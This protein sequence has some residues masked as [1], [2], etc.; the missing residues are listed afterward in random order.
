M[1]VLQIIVAPELNSQ[2]EI[3]IN[4]PERRSANLI[5]NWKSYNINPVVCY[6]RWGQL[7]SVF[8]KAEVLLIDYDCGPKSNWHAVCD[9][10]TIVKR[11]K[12]DLIHTQGSP[13]VD[14]WAS[15]AGYYSK[16]PNIV[17]RPSM[18]AQNRR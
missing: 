8:Q 12:V 7:W 11:N 10:T 9:I 16:T 6:P 15:I 14:L 1:N 18:I 13:S 5:S 17:T 2:G 4:G 3:G